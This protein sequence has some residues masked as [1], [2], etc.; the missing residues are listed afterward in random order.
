MRAPLTPEVHRLSLAAGRR[1]GGRE[2]ALRWPPGRRRRPAAASVQRSGS[3]AMGGVRWR[4]GV[5][6]KRAGERAHV[7]Q[8]DKTQTLRICAKLRAHVLE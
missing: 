6:R 3:T 7:V 1:G 2:R 4:R 8:K 5:P